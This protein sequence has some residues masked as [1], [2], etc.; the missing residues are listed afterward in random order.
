MPTHLSRLRWALLACSATAL[1]FSSA[2]VAANKTGA[3]L[4]VVDSAGKTLAEHYQYTGKTRV[5]T[6]PK[7]DCFGDGTEG[8]GKRYR[9]SEPSATG[10]LSHGSQYQSKLR[11]LQLTDAFFPDFGLG[12]CA[13]GG[14]SEPDGFWYL[15]RNHVGATVAG[16]LLPVKGRDEIL[17][18][19]IEDFSE[20]T[21]AELTI[22]ADNTVVKGAPIEVRAFEYDD[23][24]KKRPAEGVRFKGTGVQTGADGR[25]EVPAQGASTRLKG[26]RDDAIPSNRLEICQV[27]RLSQCPDDHTLDVR[28]T[29]QRDRIKLPKGGPA[30]VN[31]Y[32]GRDKVDIRRVLESGP[33][34]IKCGTGKDVVVA[35]K[36]QRFSAAGSCEKVRRG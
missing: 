33:P 7:A 35:R 29:D 1:M 4:R 15:K 26:T 6:S 16:D 17:W 10:L 25:A 18:Y 28:G 21:P 9:L 20:P 23:V 30:V 5:K 32:G 24:G 14:R 19:L 8:S 3:S 36:G 34:I 22:K 13:I 27:Q 12:V 2:A 31:A 11:P